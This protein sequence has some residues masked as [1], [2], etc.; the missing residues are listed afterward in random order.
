[1]QASL[2]GR[3]TQPHRRAGF[4]PVVGVGQEKQ[5]QKQVDLRSGAWRRQRVEKQNWGWVE[6]R[7]ESIARDT[8]FKLGQAKISILG[9][10]PRTN[11][12]G[13]DEQAS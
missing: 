7:D 6:V 3:H 13:T 11:R 5:G 8:K 9:A 4:L 2:R 10:N 1:M 12:A